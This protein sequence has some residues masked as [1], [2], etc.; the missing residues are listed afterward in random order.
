MEEMS[1]MTQQNADNAKH[2]NSLMEE[3]K[4]TVQ[5][6]D[7][8]MKELTV[9][10][11]EISGASEET[12]KI[13]K[14]IDEIAFQ[15]N[16]LALNAAVE[17]ARAGEAGAGFAVV[18]EEVR[19]LAMRA[20]EAAKSTSVLIEGTVKKI[21]AGSDLVNKTNE[22]FIEVAKN[23]GKV[24]ELIEEISAAST[25]QAQG[26]GQVSKAVAEMDKVVQQNA[27]NAEESASAAEEMNAQAQNM[28]GITDSLNQMVGSETI[29]GGSP[30]RLALLTGKRRKDGY[31]G[32]RA[33][34][35]PEHVEAKESPDSRRK[36]AIR[37]RTPVIPLEEGE[38]KDF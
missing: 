25:E 30:G 1:S 4:N 7:V 23:S 8:S 16:L 12:S 2:A 13:V 22:D 35:L 28:K 17:A 26:I 31:S 14:T 5:R 36:P 32:G 11:R 27:A 15:T 37:R 29:D 24:G 18:A 3:A 34:A 21:K 33:K 20:A 19:N 9:S 38:F 10:M 6:A